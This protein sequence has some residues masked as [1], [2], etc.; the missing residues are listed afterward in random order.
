[1]LLLAFAGTVCSSEPPPGDEDTEV[2]SSALVYPM[3]GMSASC[4]QAQAAAAA[5]QNL[6]N[7]CQSSCFESCANVSGPTCQVVIGDAPACD[8]GPLWQCVAGGQCDTKCATDA[9]CGA[10]GR[11]VNQH[12]CYPNLCSGTCGVVPDG[13]GGWQDCGSCTLPGQCLPDSFD[14]WDDWEC[15]SNNCDYWWGVCSQ[16]DLPT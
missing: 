7:S 8:G 3:T 9:S 1:V 16:W 14:C 13:C 4:D 10:S 2:L 15:C 6:E 11:C 5:M 12:C